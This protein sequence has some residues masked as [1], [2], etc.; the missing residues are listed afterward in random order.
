MMVT[1]L[2]YLSNPQVEDLTEN[3]RHAALVSASAAELAASFIGADDPTP[4]VSSP[5]Q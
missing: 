2:L 5:S 4:E 1:K 3:L